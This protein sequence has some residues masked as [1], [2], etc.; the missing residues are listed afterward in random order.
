[1]SVVTAAAAVLCLEAEWAST[2]LPLLRP[3]RFLLDRS[4]LARPASALGL[5]QHRAFLAALGAYVVTAFTLAFLLKVYNAARRPDSA[6]ALG[7]LWDLASY[8]PRAAHPFVPPCYAQKAVPDLVERARKYIDEG[9][10]VVLSSHSQGSL[11]VIAAALRMKA[12]YP[13]SCEHLG[14][15]MAGSQLQWAYPRAFPAVLDIDAYQ[16]VLDGLDGRWYVL[17]RGTDP[18]G[19][20]VLSWNLRSSN[21]N[22]NACTLAK[23][24]KPVNSKPQAARPAGQGLWIT[25][26]DWWIS[27]PMPANPTNCGFTLPPFSVALQRHSGYWSHPR[28][29]QAVACAAGA[30]E[31]TT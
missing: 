19:G 6:R 18:L 3:L 28:W 21:N 9:H 4:F 12:C 7:I 31:P 29:D 11:I 26:H 1:M 2:K 27:D 14:L 23:H 16:R 17:A 8:W 20:P 15:V 25:G 30:S 5:E 13:A 22:L 10:K 24:S